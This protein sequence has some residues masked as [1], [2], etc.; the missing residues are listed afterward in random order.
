MHDKEEL[1]DTTMRAFNVGEN[2]LPLTKSLLR[3]INSKKRRLF[4]F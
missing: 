3:D 2:P 4:L 1:T